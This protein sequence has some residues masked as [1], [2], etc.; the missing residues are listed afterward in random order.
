MTQLAFSGS[1]AALEWL[2]WFFTEPS[3]GDTTVKTGN[4]LTIT[5]TPVSATSPYAVIELQGES[6][7]YKD[8]VF[9]GKLT[10]LLLKDEIDGGGLAVR[11][12]LTGHD[13]DLSELST[14][15]NNALLGDGNDIIL[16][17]EA[18]LLPVTDIVGSPGDDYFLGSA[19]YVASSVDLGDGD[20]IY[21]MGPEFVGLRPH[22]RPISMDGGDGYDILD[23]SRSYFDY[24]GIS[25]NLASG[26]L[27]EKDGT[28]YKVTGFE[29]VIATKGPDKVIGSDSADRIV[30]GDGN[31]LIQSGGGD[32]VIDASGAGKDTLDGGDG[33]DTILLGA[34]GKAVDGGD[35]DDVIALGAGSATI[36]GGA[37]QD[38]LVLDATG[39]GYAL[40]LRTGSISAATGTKH[41]ISGIEVILAS[42]FDDSLGGDSDGNAFVGGSGNDL[43]EGR[44]GNDTIEGGDGNDTI[45]GGADD[46]F[47]TEGDGY[48]LIDLGVGNDRYTFALE[49]LTDTRD[50]VLGG[51]GNDTMVSGDA[52]V[53]FEGDAGQDQLTGGLASDTL[54]GGDDADE[55]L[56][57]G[58]ADIVRGGAGADTIFADG[59][60]AQVHG[61][62]GAD[63]IHIGSA[64]KAFGGKGNDTIR[65]AT[66]D[67][68]GSVVSGR[69]GQDLIELG[70][71]DDVYK[72]GENQSSAARDTVHG[73]AGNDTM[74]ARHGSDFLRGEEGWDVL[75]GGQGNNRLSG[76]IGNDLLEGRHGDDTLAGGGGNDTLI[77]DPGQD[78]LRGGD[79][80]DLFVFDAARFGFDTVYDFSSDRLRMV[81]PGEAQDLEAFLGASTQTTEGVLYDFGD[82]GINRILFIGHTIASL[83]D[84]A[85]IFV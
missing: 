51:Q 56:G 83:G 38:T 52:P 66:S 12:Q 33:D 68:D 15:L 13:R 50:T 55:I 1:F 10:G 43:I 22:G 37:G 81:S 11:M 30:A 75:V 71:G 7:S 34:G 53:W 70:D 80:I 85:F 64:A 63:L 62:G 8:G 17:I 59:T 41:L 19:V 48:D 78:I 67:V 77:A 24:Q 74:T 5:K 60:G 65:A 79:G 32:D 23:L 72:D 47:V 14:I 69:G 35:G 82:D 29:E 21:D 16:W 45:F 58:G 26:A 6:L 18:A 46:D 39:D 31:D 61:N 27:L 25:L 4:T 36:Q 40:D 3:L 28:L 76:G 84:E 57:G 2:S 42:G 49:D 54:N 73:G 44:S 20:D 9:S